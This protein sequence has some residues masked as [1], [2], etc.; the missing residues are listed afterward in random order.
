[1]AVA[2]RC[3]TAKNASL[4]TYKAHAEA[5]GGAPALRHPARAR[6]LDEE[7]GSAELAECDTQARHSRFFAHAHNPDF[8]PNAIVVFA[9]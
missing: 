6:R 5:L 1:L 7:L 8:L 9:E 4:T 2:P 3:R